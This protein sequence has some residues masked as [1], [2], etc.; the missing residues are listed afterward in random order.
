MTFEGIHTRDRLAAGAGDRLLFVGA[1][2]LLAGWLALSVWCVLS[3]GGL[4]AVLPRPTGVTA[5]ATTPNAGL[6]A[7]SI[8]VGDCPCTARR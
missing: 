8:G 1:P 7:V 4:A 2:L 5:R 6:V 3:L